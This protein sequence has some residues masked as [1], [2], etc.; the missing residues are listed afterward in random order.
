V[1]LF[2]A[3]CDKPWRGFLR[4]KSA[5]LRLQQSEAPAQGDPELPPTSRASSNKSVVVPQSRAT[6]PDNKSEGQCRRNRASPPS[7]HRSCQACKRLRSRDRRG[8]D[9]RG[10]RFSRANVVAQ[11]HYRSWNSEFRGSRFP[12]L[13]V[14]AKSWFKQDD[15]PG[16]VAPLLTRQALPIMRHSA[17]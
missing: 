9:F 11:K 14:Y 12:V 4:P 7:L 17:P 1:P 15:L 13:I 10:A 8:S 16:E 3:K 5:L 2:R 6:R